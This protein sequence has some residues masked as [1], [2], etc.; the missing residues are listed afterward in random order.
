MRA[1]GECGLDFSRARTRESRDQ[2]VA[3]FRTHVELAR[4]TGLP[5]SIH[6][7]KAHG[8]LVEIMRERALP[9]AVLHAYSGSA[10]LARVLV[11]AGH[12]VSFAAN[13]CIPGARK[14]VDAVRSV[15]E[16]R[17]LLETDTPDQTPPSR[18]PAANEPA[19]IVD[20]AERVASLRDV[21]LGALARATFDNARRVFAIDDPL[22]DG[23]DHAVSE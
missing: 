13:V 11:D 14:V 4:T 2:Q 1:I 23:A 3:V 21:E 22:D 9:P 19:F 8:P 18:R 12:Y 7:V 16:D 5:L 15:P 17:L 10:E 20:V 6:C